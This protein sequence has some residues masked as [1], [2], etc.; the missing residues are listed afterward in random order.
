[1]LANRKQ[2]WIQTQLPPG[3]RLAR[4]RAI[5]DCN[6]QLQPFVQ[7]QRE[8]AERSRDELSDEIRASQILGSREFSFC[9]FPIELMQQLKRLAE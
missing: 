4:H 3:E 9:L 6:E 1:V 7:S 2:K 8:A 5:V